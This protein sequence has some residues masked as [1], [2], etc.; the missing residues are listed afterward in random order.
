MR[1]EPDF[2]DRLETYAARSMEA[3]KVPGLALTIVQDDAA[4]VRKGLGRRRLGSQPRVRPDTLFQI[5]SCG[6][7]FTATALAI[8][9]DEGKLAWDDPVIDHL[10]EFRLSDA[11]LT[12]HVTVRDLLTHR[13]GLPGGDA[14]WM[15]A[16]YDRKETLR[17]LR[18][19]RPVH[20]LRERFVYQNLMYVVAGEVVGAASGIGWDAFVRRRILRPLRMTSTLT[21]TAELRARRNVAEPHADVRGRI[22]GV[23]RWEDP[24]GSGDGSI[25]STAADMVPWLRFQLSEGALGDVRLLRRTT[26]REMHTSQIVVGA[27][28]WE[29]D[30]LRAM[31]IRR[32]SMAY[33][34]GWIVMDYHGLR[35]VRH[36]GGIDGMSCV[37]ALVPE[38]RLGIAVLTNL[39][40]TPLPEA[41]AFW[42]IDRRLGRPER[43]WTSKF[44]RIARG[45]QAREAAKG[46]RK[47]AAR[48]RGTQ[49][50]LPLA[51]YAGRY[52]DAYYG[53]AAVRF[54]RGRLLLEYGKAVAGPLTHWHYDT[55]R[56]RPVRPPT[57]RSGYLTFTVGSDGRVEA[58]KV[59]AGLGEELRFV[60]RR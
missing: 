38:E 10:P 27:D 54:R 60:R 21:N 56:L 24:V 15:S 52:E 36:A 6:K 5:A 9:A 49:P 19:L 31:G 26:F 47:E 57:L 7:A 4:L 44:L 8:L 59:D 48:V 43:D 12:A 39:E 33:G 20:G 23:E 25:L 11:Y 55:F 58:M 53:A 37:V 45:L 32:P 18:S 14:L 3:A 29:L 22:Q 34:L 46:R 30:F 28:R 41:L 13:T 17:R 35:I 50:S 51:A 2:L 42:I 1:S 40:S 16:Q